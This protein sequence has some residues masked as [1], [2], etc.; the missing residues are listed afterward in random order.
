MGSERNV[1]FTAGFGRCRRP[2]VRAQF[3]I[4]SW[5]EYSRSSVHV[6]ASIPASPRPAPSARTPAR[7][8]FA[9]VYQRGPRPLARKPDPTLSRS[10]RLLH[11]GVSCANPVCGRDATLDPGGAGGNRGDRRRQW[12]T[13]AGD[14]GLSIQGRGMVVRRKALPS[15]LHRRQSLQHNCKPWTGRPSSN[16][17]PKYGSARLPRRRSDGYQ[18]GDKR[19]VAHY[20]H[21][22]LRNDRAL[23]RQRSRGRRCGEHLVAVAERRDGLA[24]ASVMRGI[25]EQPNLAA[26]TKWIYQP[27]H[28]SGQHYLIGDP[29]G[30]ASIEASATLVSN[31]LWKDSPVFLHTNHPVAAPRNE[32]LRKAEENSRGRY[33]LQF[34]GHQDAHP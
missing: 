25:L 5:A 19:G 30:F 12:T 4:V 34:D 31:I 7:R 32:R 28:A 10:S 13:L 3:S 2:A 22:D 8:G 16:S 17:R 14:L 1:G 20:G 18:H 24:V 23:R 29:R 33:A 26:A 27:R 6:F 21:D 11:R 15:S 9:K